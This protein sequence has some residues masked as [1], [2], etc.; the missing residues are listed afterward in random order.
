[1]ANGY[2]SKRTIRINKLHSYKDERKQQRE[3]LDKTNSQTT[4]SENRCTGGTSISCSSDGYCGNVLIHKCVLMSIGWEKKTF[5]I[6]E[7]TKPSA[8]KVLWFVR[9]SCLINVICIVHWYP[10]RFPYQMYCIPAP[11]S[12]VHLI[13]VFVGW[14]VIIIQPIFAEREVIPFPSQACLPTFDVGLSLEFLLTIFV[15]WF[16]FP[17]FAYVWCWAT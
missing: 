8:I 10:T 3:L 5:K 9:I 14:K 16:V 2:S 17:H 6:S 11:T 4:G 1:V 13:E 7:S 15:C 12:S